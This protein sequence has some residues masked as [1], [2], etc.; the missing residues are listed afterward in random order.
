MKMDE[1]GAFSNIKRASKAIKWA[2]PYWIYWFS[3]TQTYEGTSPSSKEDGL[4]RDSQVDSF[5][6]W[7]ML[8]PQRLKGYYMWCA[9][10][11]IWVINTMNYN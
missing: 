5:D 3:G 11:I 6:S 10:G 7:I 2:Y 9:P 4:D 1:N 8:G